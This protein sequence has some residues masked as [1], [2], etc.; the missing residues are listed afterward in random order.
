V[1]SNNITE[2]CNQVHDISNIC[3][4]LCAKTLKVCLDQAIEPSYNNPFAAC[5]EFTQ[6]CNYIC[7][8]VTT[9]CLP[10]NYPINHKYSDNQNIAMV[11]VLIIEGLLA[12]VGLSL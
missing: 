9:M 3:S 12:I 8:N 7:N 4:D 11:F 1:I 6:N 5:Q 10:T 2:L